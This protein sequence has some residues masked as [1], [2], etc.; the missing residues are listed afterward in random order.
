MPQLLLLNGTVNRATL[1]SRYP[2]Y[3]KQNILCVSRVLVTCSVTG[4]YNVTSADVASRETWVAQLTLPSPIRRYISFAVAKTV[5]TALID[6]RLDYYNPVYHNIELKH[7]L[8]LQRVQNCLARVV[9]RSPRFSHSAPLL[10]SLHWLPVRYHINLKICTITYQA[11]S[12][13]QLAYL[14][15][16]LTPA[17]QPRSLRSSNFNLVFVLSVIIH[18]VTMFVCITVTIYS[19]E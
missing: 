3:R 12:S 5:A 14:R 19:A 7:I 4:W 8:K 16:L 11:L 13:K 10:K 1:S 15:S 17:R 18:V 9:T 2:V 6:S